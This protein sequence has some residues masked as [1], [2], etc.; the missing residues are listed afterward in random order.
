MIFI[1]YPFLTIEKENTQNSQIKSF[2]FQP[3][4]FYGV[5]LY[6]LFFPTLQSLAKI[7]N[8]GG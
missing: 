7:K 2:G 1:K 8:F 6:I 3:K 5:S 4:S